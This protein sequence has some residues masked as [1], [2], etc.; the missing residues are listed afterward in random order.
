L[1]M[2]NTSVSIPV[3]PV[4][5]ALNAV[6]E[7]LESVR[8]AAAWALTDDE[9]ETAIGECERL[10]ARQAELR[11][12]LL[13]EADGRDL[14]RRKG[15]SS[16]P[17][18]LRDRFRLRPA[19]AKWHLNVANR[20]AAAADG[21]PVDYAANVNGPPTG[22]EMPATGAALAAGEISEQHAVVVAKAMAKLP[23]TLAPEAAA[24]A[25]R[26]LAAYARQFDPA[27]LAKLADCLVDALLPD[28]LEDDEEDAVDKRELRFSDLT[29]RLSGRLDPEGLALVR[30][31]LDPLAAPRPSEDGEKDD[32]SP[33]RRM[34]DALVEIARRVLNQG[35]WLPAEHGNRPH[36]ML[37]SEF[38]ADGSEGTVADR[39]D[40]GD[41]GDGVAGGSAADA[42]ANSD[43]A[44][45]A[46]SGDNEVTT[47]GVP[48]APAGARA[49]GV[50]PEPAGLAGRLGRGGLTWGRPL[51]AASV[52]RI[53]CDAAI[54]WIITDS[55][56]VPLR[57]GREQRTV[58]P[59]QWAALVARDG[60]CGFPGC[61][62]PVEWCE[63]H[64]ILWWRY[65]G[66][67]DLDNLCLLCADHH[68]AV[69]HRGWDIRLGADKRPDFLPPPW[70]DP[71]R[72]P[73]RNNRP[74]YFRNKGP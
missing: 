14:G 60:G 54:T 24:E 26:Q 48:A 31:M 40:G 10:A 6:D 52:R 32:R 42:A 45:T 59:G 61:T 34:A 20:I 62:R 39:A 12:R 58:T 28:T 56:G 51:S 9:L 41:G 17:A 7:A 18:W 69:H 71:D 33:A 25:E 49:G 16:T 5:A 4:V 1:N 11:L 35:E 65:G 19:D 63:A 66:R 27:A 64:H 21:G 47:Q 22:R 36:L 43:S 38:G 50:S 15:A 73:R 3:H 70:V 13:A 68:R 46:D 55:A 8:E 53:A 29:G 74:R 44:A 23:T 2:S 30:A 37:I 67:T 57:V 72:T